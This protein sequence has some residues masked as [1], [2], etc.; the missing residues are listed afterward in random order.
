MAK[1]IFYEVIVLRYLKI[2]CVLA[3]VLLL[4]GKANA[5]PFNLSGDWKMNANGWIYEL[6]LLEK[7]DVLDG[8]LHPI[9][10]QAP[11]MPITG[12]VFADGRIEFS[13][14]QAGTVQH[15]TGHVFQGGEKANAMSGLFSQQGGQQFA[16]FAE[17][18]VQNAKSASASGGPYAPQPAYP[19]HTMI[20]MFS[21]ASMP[22][23]GTNKATRFEVDTIFDKVPKYITASFSSDVIVQQGQRLFLAGNAEGTAKW[24]VSGFLFLEFRSGHSVRRFVV[25]G[26]MD[27]IKYNGQLVEKVGAWGNYHS[28][29]EIDFSPYLPKNTP[30]RV[31]AYALHYGPGVGAVSD[32]YLHTK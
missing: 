29:A 26:G 14:G 16:W 1:S 9:N 24:R 4:S 3:V 31:T 2:F 7:G 23:S 11:D 18:V 12:R 5:S 28:P 25:G 15:F 19:E 21:S 10:H 6:V 30:L 20:K 27:R 17:R 32:I 13:Y 8:V 22:M